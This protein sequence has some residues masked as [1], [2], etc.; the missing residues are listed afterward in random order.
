[1]PPVLIVLRL[2]PCL[3]SR[4]P[5]L[6]LLLV[7]PVYRLRVRRLQRRPRLRVPPPLVPRVPPPLVPRVVQ[8]LPGLLVL[9]ALRGRRQ[10]RAIN[11]R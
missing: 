4:P 3:F 2:V 11:Q 9:P 5:R 8:A 10:A 6:V 7:L 1:M